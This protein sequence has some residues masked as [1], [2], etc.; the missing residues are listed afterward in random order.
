[1]ERPCAIGRS[2][3]ARFELE[4]HLNRAH[5]F[6]GTIFDLDSTINPPPSFQAELG[7]EN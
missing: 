2:R 4:T 7:G 3:A 5:P 6:G 1:M